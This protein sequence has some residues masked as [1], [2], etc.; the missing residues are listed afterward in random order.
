MLVLCCDDRVVTADLYIFSLIG[1]LNDWSYR[2]ERRAGQKQQMSA[3]TTHSSGRAPAPEI[4]YKHFNEC[5]NCIFKDDSRVWL[6]LI[7]M[8]GRVAP[9]P[10][11]VT[12]GN[13]LVPAWPGRC[14]V[15]ALQTFDGR[16]S[17]AARSIASPARTRPIELE[18]RS[19]T[20]KIGFGHIRKKL[21]GDCKLLYYNILIC[22]IWESIQLCTKSLYVIWCLHKK[23]AQRFIS[24]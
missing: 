19:D 16:G 9:C 7:S 18:L 5:E 12:H 8:C 23:S 4:K 15:V 20:R 2:C 11:P 13:R 21:V 1:L 10:N 24:R 14:M 6:A 3:V 17:E 22:K